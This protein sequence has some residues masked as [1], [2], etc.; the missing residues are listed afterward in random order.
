LLW[1]KLYQSWFSP[2]SKMTTLRQDGE[3][4]IWS[5]VTVHVP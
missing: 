1:L 4:K 3:C 5:L 2:F